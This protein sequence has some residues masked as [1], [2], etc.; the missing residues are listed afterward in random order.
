MLARAIEQRD[1]FANLHA[2]MQFPFSNIDIVVS[3]FLAVTFLIKL[4]RLFKS[5][6][7]KDGFK[8]KF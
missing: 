4:M 5:A 1:H 6:R 8:K 2:K 3:R 7:V